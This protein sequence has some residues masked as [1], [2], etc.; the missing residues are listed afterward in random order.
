MAHGLV[1]TGIGLDLGAIQ[2]HMAQAHH[3]RLLAEAQHLDKQ[4]LQCFQVAAAEL[5]DAAVVR[6]L[7]AAQHPESSVL[8]AGTLDFSGG[9]DADAV[10]V[11]QQHRHH[12]GVKPLLAPRILM[13]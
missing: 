4:L 9:G 5:T 1:L 7:I 10:G 6:L 11:Q 2:R 13:A 8:V 3:P 12:P